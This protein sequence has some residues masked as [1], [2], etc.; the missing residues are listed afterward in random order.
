VTAGVAAAGVGR[1]SPEWTAV[2]SPRLAGRATGVAREVLAR[3][4]DPGVVAAAISAAHR[5]TRFP[6]AIHWDPASL[7]QGDAGLAL[8]LSYA[9]AVFPDEGWDRAAHRSLTTAVRALES[10]PTRGAG[11]FDGIA[12]IAFTAGALSHGGTRYRR[13]RAGLDAALAAQVE[14]LARTVSTTVGGLGTEHFDVISGLAGVSAHLLDGGNSAGLGEVLRAFVH[15]TEPTMPPRWFT[16]APVMHNELMAAQYPHGNLNCGLAHG[17]PGPLAAMALALGSGI[18]VPGLADAAAS[19]AQWL[20]NHQ[21]PDPRG[22]DWPTVIGLNAAGVE[23]AGQE[24]ASRTAWCY[25]TPGVARAL[26]L[27]G[28]SLGDEGLRDLAVHAMAAV[29]A[30]PVAHREIDSPTFCHGVAGLLQITLRF[31][32]DTAGL[33]LFVDAAH[34][35]TEQLLSEFDS[36]RPAGFACIEPA[37]NRVDQPGLLDGAAGV[38]VTLLAAASDVDPAWDRLFLLS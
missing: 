30:R 11:M 33:P 12:G 15:L 4:C 1:R 19:V 6:E 17:I 28:T 3:V 21:Q 36:A 14:A 22:A 25:G 2:L 9:D 5:Q 8:A 10:R 31:A 26:W 29:Y 27:A 18:T 13:L 7:A 32:Q 35:L 24:G 20:G 16:P 38:A 34:A 23:T 37:G